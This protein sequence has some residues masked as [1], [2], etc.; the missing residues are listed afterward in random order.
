MEDIIV[1]VER[2]TNI[3]KAGTDIKASADLRKSTT[4]I[5]VIIGHTDQI[6]LGDM[7]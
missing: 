3:S 4:A 1:I 2:T 7:C 5:Y 6:I